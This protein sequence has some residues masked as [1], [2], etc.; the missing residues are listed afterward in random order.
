MAE[1]SAEHPALAS[2]NTLTLES[3]EG[4]LSCWQVDGA[5]CT[6]EQLGALNEHVAAPLRCAIYEVRSYPESQNSTAQNQTPKTSTNISTAPTTAFLTQSS[7]ATTPSSASTATSSKTS[8]E[9][10][11]STP[12]NHSSTAWQ[13]RTAAGQNRNTTTQNHA[14][15][16]GSQTPT[17]PKQ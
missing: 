11:G 5:L 16:T 7:T 13:H 14:P 4:A 3:S 15:A 2:I 1:K 6:R 9:N 17:P 12:Q 10:H 8:T